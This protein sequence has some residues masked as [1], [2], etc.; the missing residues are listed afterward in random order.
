MGRAGPADI[1]GE[2]AGSGVGGDTAC[3]DS[4]AEEPRPNN[5]II[6]SEVF[7]SIPVFSFFYLKG[8]SVLAFKTG[9]R[10]KKRKE[11][12]SLWKILD[13]DV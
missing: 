4:S 3:G 1:L 5:L 2:D 8:E 9:E 13:P 7:L 10:E 12:K 11:K 6:S